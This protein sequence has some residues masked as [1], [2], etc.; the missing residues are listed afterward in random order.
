LDFLRTS[1][2]EEPVETELPGAP[3]LQL[4]P[5]SGAISMA[6]HH[7]QQECI[8]L[9]L[10]AEALL[11]LAVFELHLGPGVHEKVD[12]RMLLE[13]FLGHFPILDAWIHDIVYR[14]EM[15][16]H[17]F[18]D[19]LTDVAKAVFLLLPLL[20]LVDD[21]A[22]ICEAPVMH[23][24]REVVLL[25]VVLI[26]AS[27]LD[28]IVD[29]FGDCITA[30]SLQGIAEGLEILVEMNQKNRKVSVSKINQSVLD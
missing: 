12:R 25:D 28:D 27:L 18:L 23:P 30:M 4:N 13:E 16:L 14:F 17:F 26:F 5:A 1:R 22:P 21:L 7:Y 11:S 19:H 15:K 20:D 9:L 24:E 10:V 6:M 29:N 2:L 8:F 3:Y